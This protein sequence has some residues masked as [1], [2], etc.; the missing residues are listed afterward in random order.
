MALTLWI[1][2]VQSASVVNAELQAKL[3]QL[4]AEDQAIRHDI[5][6]MS[7][8]EY[9]AFAEKLTAIDSRNFAELARIMTEG[10]ARPADLALLEDRILVGEGRKQ[11]YGSQVTAGPDGIPR[12]APID[13][14]EN[15]D[16][17]RKAL[18]L[19]PLEEYLK[20]LELRIG[21]TIERQ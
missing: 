14:P 4:G 17:R 5:P 21:K 3:L 10:R 8:P 9:K 7:S 2:A 1:G 11:R 19:P 13:D 18:G 20:D 16:S 12:L 6:P 15:V